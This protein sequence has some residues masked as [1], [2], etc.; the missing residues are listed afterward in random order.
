MKYFYSR[1][2]LLLISLHNFLTEKKNRNINLYMYI[3]T[4]VYKNFLSLTGNNLHPTA[5]VVNCCTL[6]E[7]EE[8]HG[9]NRQQ[10]DYHSNSHENRTDSEWHIGN[11][12]QVVQ[13]TNALL[14]QFTCF[15]F[16]H[17]CKFYLFFNF[18]TDIHTIFP[19]ISEKYTY[20]R[21]YFFILRAKVWMIQCG[22]T[23]FFF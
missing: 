4:S 15:F 5:N 23:F 12:W 2:C 22:L 10:S 11:R 9:K 1:K 17:S 20:S 13:T 14:D 3:S 6:T 16:L 8:Y 21:V 7:E 19:C 18:L